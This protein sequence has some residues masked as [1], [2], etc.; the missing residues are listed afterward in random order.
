[1]PSQTFFNLDKGKQAKL[2]DCA[3]EEF[4]RVPYPEVSINQIILNAKI[5]RGSFYTYFKDKN[6]LFEYIIKIYGEKLDE[7]LIGAIVK[8]NGDIRKSFIEVFDL[9]LLKIK[10]ENYIGI[11]KNAFLFFNIN[12]DKSVHPVHLIYEKVKYDIDKRCLKD[13]NLEIVFRMLLQ[14]LFISIIESL[15][16]EDDLKVKEGY[17]EKIDIICYGIYKEGSLC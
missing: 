7:V 5:S 6:E 3:F 4:I 11:F 9:L 13:S 2:I 17:L 8:N 12:R 16:N 10:K 1:M 15:K 14:T